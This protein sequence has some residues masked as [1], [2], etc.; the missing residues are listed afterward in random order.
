MVIASTRRK[1]A[2]LNDRSEKLGEVVR[3]RFTSQ[4]EPVIAGTRVPVRSIKD[5]AGAG[6]SIDKI[7]EEYPALTPAD[8]KSALRYSDENLAA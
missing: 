7:I 3:M 8:V 6:H 1:V 2:E 5:F 4:N